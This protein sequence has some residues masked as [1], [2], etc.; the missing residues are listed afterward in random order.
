ME[1]RGLTA[2]ALFVP[3]VSENLC[4]AE[5]RFPRIVALGSSLN[6]SYPPPACSQISYF[7]ADKVLQKEDVPL[8][9]NQICFKEGGPGESNSLGNTRPPA[10]CDAPFIMPCVLL[11]KPLAWIKH[12]WESVKGSQHF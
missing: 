9:H 4:L 6:R 10:L 5:A 1:G 2:L 8:L 11:A 7:W 3:C 12:C